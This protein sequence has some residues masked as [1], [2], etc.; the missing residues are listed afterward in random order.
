MN[1]QVTEFLAKTKNWP[2]ELTLLREIVLDCN[3]V[4]ELKWKQPCYVFQKANI[5]MISSFKE[6]CTI[7]FFKGVLLKDEEQLLQFP[8]ENSQSVKMLK[9]T[10]A[11][12]IVQ[13]KP[14]IKAYI[15]EAIE[16][17]KQGLSI[18]KP[19]STNLLLPE[20][21]ISVFKKDKQFKQAFEALTPGRQRAYN[22]YFTGAK[23]AATK[24][25]RIE[26]YKQRI[27]NGKGIN[28]C[29]CGLSKKM[30]SCDGSHKILNVKN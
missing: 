23:Q 27:L 14:T 12:Q 16:V 3:L 28:D 22:I 5:L 13:L 4:E 26:Q 24:I 30:P 19:L 29:T 11:K 8:G 21:L 7:S 15:Y 9:F 20:E 25:T 17:E 2:L 6:Y 18:D 10:D 1:P